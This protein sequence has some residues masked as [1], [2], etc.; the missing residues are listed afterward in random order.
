MH[1][2]D[3]YRCVYNTLAK[4]DSNTAVDTEYILFSE[5]AEDM[6]SFPFASLLC[7]IF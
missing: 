5:T 6:N 4:G 7:T 1:K 2:S 3:V